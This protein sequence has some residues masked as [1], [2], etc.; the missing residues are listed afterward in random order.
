MRLGVRPQPAQAQ[1]IDQPATALGALEAAWWPRALAGEK[2]ATAQVLAIRK[3]RAELERD[4]EAKRA[5]GEAGNVVEV[6]VAFA[7][8]WREVRRGG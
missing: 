1:T 6:R 3:H 8:D 2:G 5:E 7:D 4:V